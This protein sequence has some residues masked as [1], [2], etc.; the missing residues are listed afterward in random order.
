ME[1]QFNDTFSENHV[2]TNGMN[3]VADRT[4]EIIILGSEGVTMPGT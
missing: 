3:R 4:E 2:Q 1:G